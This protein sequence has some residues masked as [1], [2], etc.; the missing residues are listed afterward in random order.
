MWQYED[1]RIKGNRGRGK[2]HPEVQIKSSTKRKVVCDSPFFVR[3][4]VKGRVDEA[5]KRVL[6]NVMLGAWGR[7]GRRAVMNRKR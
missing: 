5:S 1:I 2:L 4:D 3:H 7:G 6:Q